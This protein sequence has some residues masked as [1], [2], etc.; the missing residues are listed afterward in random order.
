MMSTSAA[1]PLNP[2]ERRGVILLLLALVGFGVLVEV[3]SAF[4]ERRM[5]DLGCYLRAAWALRAGEN[6]YDVVDDNRWHY[7]YP[8]LYAVLMMPLADPP[9]EA[10]A[11]GYVP[12]AVSA[13]VCYAL[14]VLWLV[15]GVHWLASALESTAPCAATTR[16]WWLL[17]TLPI[18]VC[19]TTIGHTLNRGQTNVLLL[20]LVCGLI[21]GLITGRRF[22]AGLF[23]AGA[24]CLKVFPAFLLLVPLWR[25]DARC[26]A[27]CI[28]GLFCGLLVIPMAAMGPDR[29]VAAY[30]DFARVTI[31]PAL[32]MS[33]DTSRAK[34]LI[35]TTATDNQSFQMVLQAS[36]HPDRDTRPPQPSLLVR[37]VS[38]G[39][40]ALLTLL[41]LWA[42][43]SGRARTGSGLALFIGCLAIV[44][45]M[46][47]PVC[48]SHYFVLELP[49]AA[50][51]LALAWEKRPHLNGP[52][53]G[54]A[55]NSPLDWKMA[56]SFHDD[57]CGERAAPDI[58]LDRLAR[59][60]C[61]GAGRAAVVVR[62]MAGTGTASDGTSGDRVKATR[63][64]AGSLAIAFA[65][66][67]NVN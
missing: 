23:L 57:F 31:G 59:S 6:L 42:G 34:E 51:L 65:P 53:L 4:L 44:M 20:M 27:G 52:T 15:L 56:A 18:F 22:R 55:R 10:D 33:N 21:A 58:C 64:T 39:F 62:G 35:E 38:I 19:L 8:P 36:L 54:S 50:G 25:R 43:R 3:R 61:A 41:T 47:S 29:M 45:L 16:R 48:H 60:R 40:G 12:Y 46:L 67:P 28:V 2:W 11:A 49:L 37:G 30:R 32:G 66:L 24:I 9:R 14:N 26:L 7:N 17:R 63:P 13:G 5:G 1:E